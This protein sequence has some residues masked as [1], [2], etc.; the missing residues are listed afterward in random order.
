M[1]F[2]GNTKD[3]TG[4]G[5]NGLLSGDV[6]FSSD[7]NGQAGRAALFNLNGLRGQGYISIPNTPSIM[8]LNTKITIACWVLVT[9]NDNVFT[10]VLCKI[11]I[12]YGILFFSVACK[13]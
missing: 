12:A 9:S 1:P 4:F 7:R 6:T 5:N 10:V 13:L 11:S 2:D 8:G 3:L